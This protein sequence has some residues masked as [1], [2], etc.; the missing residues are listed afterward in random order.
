MIECI[1]NDKKGLFIIKIT[2]FILNLKTVIL[3]NDEK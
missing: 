3:I 1:K 2:F